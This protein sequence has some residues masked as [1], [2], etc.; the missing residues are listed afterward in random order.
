MRRIPWSQPVAS[1]TRM[2]SMEPDEVR[3][4][5]ASAGRSLAASGINVDLAPV[6][7][8]PDDRQSFMR[9]SFQLDGVL[10]RIDVFVDRMASENRMR[11]EARHLLKEAFLRGRFSRTDAERITDTTDK[12]LKKISDELIA[13]GR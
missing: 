10:R 2:G 9:D 8:V 3:S 1:A 6:A 13:L 4:I 12:T 5:G 7:D 11:D